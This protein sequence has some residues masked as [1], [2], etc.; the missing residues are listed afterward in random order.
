L[1]RQTENRW[2]T[3][4]ENAWYIFSENKWYIIARELT[5]SAKNLVGYAGLG[6]QV[7]DSGQTTHTGKIT[8]AGRR[9]LRAAMVEAA[10]TA[11]LHDPLWKAQFK[12]MES[13]LGY[14][15]TIIAIARKML[16]AVWYILTKQVCNRFAETELVTHKFMQY[17]YRIGKE[18]RPKDQ[19]PT[20]GSPGEYS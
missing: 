6:T 9:D 11:V 19:S 7:H 20:A 5:P 10:H 8:K 16:V 15:K 12:Q 14:N 17:T 18:N 3:F 1:A 2:R 13:R 4:A